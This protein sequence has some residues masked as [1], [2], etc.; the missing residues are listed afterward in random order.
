MA[1]ITHSSM[2]YIIDDGIPFPFGYIL[3]I[4]ILIFITICIHN[5]RSSREPAII[6]DNRSKLEI[7]TDNHTGVQYL[8]NKYGLVLR[9]DVAGMPYCVDAERLG[10]LEKE[11]INK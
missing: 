2:P 5:Y 4:L 6:I 1:K 8:G 3:V 10:S 7:F 9:V 11:E